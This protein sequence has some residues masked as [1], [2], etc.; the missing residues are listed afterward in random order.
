MTGND[1]NRES[2]INSF[3]LKKADMLRKMSPLHQQSSGD[4]EGTE[5][6]ECS[7]SDQD[8]RKPPAIDRANE[9]GEAVFVDNDDQGAELGKVDLSSQLSHIIPSSSR[10]PQDILC[11]KLSPLMDRCSPALLCSCTFSFTSKDAECHFKVIRVI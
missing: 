7:N 11:G 1:E 10:T 6:D 3:G 5:D 9:Q 8:D 4:D 2:T